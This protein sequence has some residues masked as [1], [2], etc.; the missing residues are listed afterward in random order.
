M[1]NARRRERGFNLQ[2]ETVHEVYNENYMLLDDFADDEVGQF[3]GG[4]V[5]YRVTRRWDNG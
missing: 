4:G 1:R 5:L 3:F 2:G